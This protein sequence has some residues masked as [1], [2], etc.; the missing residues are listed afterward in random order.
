MTMQGENY[1][2]LS[3]RYLENALHFLEQGDV[4]KAG[5]FL[6]GSMSAALKAVAA[7]NGIPI[8]SHSQLRAFAR[9]V[10]DD[11]NEPGVWTDFVRA[12]HLHSNFY[13]ASLEMEDVAREVDDIGRRVALLLQMAAEPA[14]RGS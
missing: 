6:W 12:Q 1:P 8:Q 10:A 14:D 13:E 9:R 11:T 4:E 7:R 2:R 3:I 5:E